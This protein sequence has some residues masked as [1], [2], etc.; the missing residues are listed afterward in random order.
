MLVVEIADTS[1]GYD[2]GRKTA[3]Y[4][5]FGIAK[6]WVVNAVKLATRIHC[7]PTPTGYRSILDLPADHPLVPELGPA[8][9]VTLSDLDLR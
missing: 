7:D 5:A 3:L 4:A 2:L 6:L 1:L 9:S 8:L